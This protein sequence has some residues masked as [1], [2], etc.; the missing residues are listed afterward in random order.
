[1]A[2]PLLALSDIRRNPLLEG[3]GWPT[4]QPQSTTGQLILR[5]WD[6]EHGACAMLHHLQNGTAGRLAM[7][8]SGN[9]SDWSPSAYIR[10]VLNRTTLHYLFITN[11]DQDH[12]S[13]LQRLWDRRISVPVWHRNPSITPEVFRKIKAQNGPLTSDA[14]RYL[15]N[16]TGMTYAVGEPFDQYMGGIKSHLFWNCYPHFTTTN[17]LSL[18]VFITFAGFKILFPGDLEEAGWLA[19]LKKPDFCAELATTDIL[20][21][22]HHGRTNGYCENVFDYCHPQAVVMS[23]K[24]IIHDTQLLMARSIVMRLSST[25]QTESM[26]LRP[27]SAGMC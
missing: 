19:L 18:V 21:A 27:A 3:G 11:A 8:D 9:S 4:S 20:V 17:D 2:N 15:Q 7:I 22:S 23:D 25:I 1:V 6:V 14:T 13:D 24:S 5:I 10:N 12:I 16:L 26:L